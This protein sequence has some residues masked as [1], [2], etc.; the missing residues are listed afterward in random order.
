MERGAERKEKTGGGLGEGGRREGGRLRA[1]GNASRKK[2]EQS[3]GGA[4]H[5]EALVFLLRQMLTRATNYAAG[6]L[7]VSSASSPGLVLLLRFSARSARHDIMEIGV[8]GV[9]THI[10]V[11]YAFRSTTT[12]A[13][14]E[15][16][17]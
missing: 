1:E 16:L 4:S 13:A 15:S 11:S 2:D 12:T 10:R 17:P 8:P 5:A 6:S 14:A 7:L 3:G 9:G